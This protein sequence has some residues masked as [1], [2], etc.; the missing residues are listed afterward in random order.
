MPGFFGSEVNLE[1]TTDWVTHEKL[2]TTVSLVDWKIVL[3][4]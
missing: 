1:R 2:E 3:V 4:V